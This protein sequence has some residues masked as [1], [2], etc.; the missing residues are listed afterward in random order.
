VVGSGS[1]QRL[2]FFA[3]QDFIDDGQFANSARSSASDSLLL[4]KQRVANFVP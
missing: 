4:N 1:L 2:N 3:I